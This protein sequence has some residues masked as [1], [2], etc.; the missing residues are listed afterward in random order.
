MQAS[1]LPVVSSSKNNQLRKTSISFNE[2]TEEIRSMLCKVNPEDFLL[3]RK[4]GEG[5]MGEVFE[6]TYRGTK[7]AAKRLKKSVTKSG[8][9]CN[10]LLVE[11]HSLAKVGLH[12][13]IVTFYGACIQEESSPGESPLYKS[14]N[15]VL[16][17]KSIFYKVSLKRDKHRKK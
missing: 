2:E 14:A 10:D 15:L 11:A 16:L 8:V 4:L 9:P 13:N 6:C 12:P 1:K 3:G 17:Q 7:C 5:S